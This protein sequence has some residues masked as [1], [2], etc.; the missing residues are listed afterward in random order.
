MEQIFDVN[1][2]AVGRFFYGRERELEFFRRELFA[3]AAQGVSRYYSVT[4]MK[5]IGKSSLFRELCR[6]FREEGHPN[7]AV[8][9]SSLD[10]VKGF[11][12]FW[13]REVLR[14]LFAVPAFEGALSG[15]EEED[16]AFIRECRGYFL[17]Q[18]NWRLLYEG[19]IVQDM[20]A[21]D[22]LE[23]LFPVLY[24]AG[25]YMVLVID[26]FDQAGRVFGMQEE[27]FGWFR[28][29]LQDNMG[30]SV[31]TLSRRSIRFIE[32][33]CFGGSTF[34]GIFSKRGLFGYS[35]RELDAYFG[36]LE[37]HGRKLEEPKR[38]DIWYYC[39]RSPFYL[40][41]MG[42]ALLQDPLAAP[43]VVAGQFIDSFE[44]VL[45]SLKEEK[46]LSAVLQMF[47]G[48][49]YRMGEAEVQK[50]VALGYCMRRATLDCGVAGGGEYADYFAPEQT[51]EYLAVCG[52]FIDY[53]REAHRAEADA[54]WPMLTAT[55]QRL[56]RVI[57]EEYSKLYPGGWKEQLEQIVLNGG[58]GDFRAAF[59]Q[60]HERMYQRAGEDQQRNVGN[61]ILNV[62]S[63]RTL[64]FLIRDQWAVF[65][66]YFPGGS[67]DFADGME[68]L[69]QA[70]NPISHS[71]GELL[72]PADIAAVERI[73]A[74][75]AAGIDR[76]TAAEADGNVGV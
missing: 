68:T 19:D 49:R 5:R 31:A 42:Q 38:K 64:S 71:N 48:P 53:L 29:L 45:A 11:W 9:E 46:L 33:N 39:G 50:L 72:T 13:I 60:E 61:S 73:C 52:Y 25:L 40:A 44:A 23:R 10:G 27:N 20:V 4:G 62:V 3:P 28:G 59:L 67:T 57:E 36:L 24:D 15:M 74:R 14:P 65:A 12:Q 41:I 75:F 1:H 8:I 55:E 21:R 51:G 43:E 7:V 34:D 70:R 16:A 22:Y 54:I 37:E 6:R 56:R 69:Y 58:R 47:V 66:K 63:L 35:N 30:L 17:D 18:G 2:A 26:E 76:V 32:K